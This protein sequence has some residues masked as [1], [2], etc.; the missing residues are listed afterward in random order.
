ML[1]CQIVT[2]KTSIFFKTSRS[3]HH[4]FLQISHWKYQLSQRINIKTP[5]FL[6]KYHAKNRILFWK[7]HAFLSKS[8]QRRETTICRAA[9]LHPLGYESIRLCATFW[10]NYCCA[11][12]AL[13]LVWNNWSKFTHAEWNRE[14]KNMDI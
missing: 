11:F 8:R 12:A 4:V 1:S 9:A 14:G 10:D 6:T 13:A 5:S 2:W 3:E 7:H